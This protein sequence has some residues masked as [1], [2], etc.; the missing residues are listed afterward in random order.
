MAITHYVQ[1]HWK[2]GLLGILTLLILII[3]LGF[4]LGYYWRLKMRQELHSYV[5]QMTDSLYSLRYENMRLD[6]FGGDLL[7]TKVS[8]TPDSAVYHRMQREQRAKPFVCAVAADKLDLQ[9]FRVW[10]YFRQKKVEAS[11]LIFTNPSLVVNVDTRPKDTTV[12]KSFYQ[13]MSK[14]LKEIRIGRLELLNTNMNYT[15]DRPD[16]NQMRMQVA[17][18]DIRITG[19]LVDSVSQHDPARYFYGENCQIDLK[20][21]R[22]RN[23]DS[24]YWMK[25]HELHYDAAAQT[26]SIDSFHLDPIYDY[27]AFDRQAKIQKDRFD[28]KLNKVV[29]R[30]FDPYTL[31]QG[32]IK[33]RSV[34]IASGQVHV[35]HNR[36]LPMDPK[37]KLG[38]HPN[39]MI[40]R[41]KLPLHIDTLLAKEMDVEY[42]EVSPVTGETGV[43]NFIHASGILTNITNLDSMLAKDSHM[44][45]N[46]HALLMGQGDLTAR[47]D[48]PIADSAGGFSLTG[49][50]KNMD[51]RKMNQMVRPLN[52][53]EVTSLQIHTLSFNISGN[54]YKAAGTVDFKYDSLKIAFLQKTDD[55]KHAKKSGIGTF[56]ANAFGLKNNSPKEGDAPAAARV[57]LERDTHKSFFNLVWKTIFKG[58][59][60]TAGSSLLK[61]IV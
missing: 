29:L 21:Y 4:S 35:Y 1:K 9:G 19:L 23:S 60:Q 52:R 43:L 27:A 46:L 50:L 51:G 59:K 7:L 22:Y 18:M 33:T 39:Q 10:R 32:G 16:A 47:F 6:I 2:K 24:V 42:R 28:V 17:Q 5:L 45:I 8:L 25:V 36:M 58:I 49:V 13:S 30:N 15:F 14:K 48:F 56:L 55:T 41:M 54:Q 34:N 20:D 38:K 31:L 57:E 3:A 53:V 26:L 61:S 40:A 12:P 11:A 44:I 37:T